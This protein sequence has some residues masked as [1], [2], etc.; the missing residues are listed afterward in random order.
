MSTNPKLV[1]RRKKSPTLEEAQGFVGGH[2]ELVM[3]NDGSQMILNENGMT[4]KLPSNR[5]A[6]RIAKNSG[7]NMG[8]RGILGNVLFLRGE[9]KWK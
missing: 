3:L 4:E 6:T 2:V 8:Y 7:V 9:A 1:I 5:H